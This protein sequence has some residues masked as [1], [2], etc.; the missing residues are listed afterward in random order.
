MRKIHRILLVSAVVFILGATACGPATQPPISTQAATLSALLTSS[1]IAVATQSTEST[2][3]VGTGTPSAGLPSTSEGTST[4][5]T[6]TPAASISMTPGIP[7]TGSSEALLIC[8]FCLDRIPYAIVAIPETATF[9]MV[10]EQGATI[11]PSDETTCDSAQ[12]FNGRQIILCRGAQLTTINLSICTGAN[13]CVQFPVK[14]QSCPEAGSSGGVATLPAGT[15]TGTP[16]ASVTGT[17]SA[18]APGTAATP[19]P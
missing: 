10:D 5:V 13:N 14:L 2:Q 16:G 1:P 3:G 7:V 12:T 8:Q 19:T 9:N 6:G 15:A 4:G 18:S 17:P 11:K